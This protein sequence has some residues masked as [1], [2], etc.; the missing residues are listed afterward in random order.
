VDLW[1]VHLR[2]EETDDPEPIA[3]T[4]LTTVPVHPFDDA[5]ERAE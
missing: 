5:V 4:L 3:W 1:A 2:A